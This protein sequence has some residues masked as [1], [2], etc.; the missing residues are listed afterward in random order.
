MR[1]AKTETEVDKFKEDIVRML[2]NFTV[3]HV[4]QTYMENKELF[5]NRAYNIHEPSDDENEAQIVR[6]A[7]E[8]EEE[9]GK[10]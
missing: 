3:Y 4:K 1:V 5:D 7:E 10:E 6:E 8:S 2:S 9:E